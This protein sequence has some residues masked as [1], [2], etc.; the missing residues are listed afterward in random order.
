MNVSM[1]EDDDDDAD[2]DEDCAASRCMKPSGRAVNWVQCDGGCEMWF[3]LI[4][5]G[6]TK[7]DVADVEFLCSKCKKKKDPEGIIDITM[8]EVGD[9]GK[10]ILIGDELV[11]Q[12]QQS[13]QDK[14]QQSL[15]QEKQS[16]HSATLTD[17]RRGASPLSSLAAE[18]EA[19]S[20]V[21]TPF[22][23]TLSC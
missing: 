23:P 2:D 13:H 5:V 20:N 12:Q 3:H 15:Q 10:P 4:C 17:S 9:R 11:L 22:S 16:C 7:L 19:M 21:S 18:P 1:G 8:D 6:L 14:K